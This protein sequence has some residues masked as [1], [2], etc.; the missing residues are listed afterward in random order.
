MPVPFPTA[1]PVPPVPVQVQV[2]VPLVPVLVTVPASILARGSRGEFG[3]IHR[4]TGDRDEGA[5]ARL[6]A[7]AAFLSTTQRVYGMRIG[8][9]EHVDWQQVG[10]LAANMACRMTADDPRDDETVGR[11]DNSSAEQYLFTDHETRT[12]ERLDP[13]ADAP[14]ETRDREESYHELHAYHRTPGSSPELTCPGRA[15]L[16]ADGRWTWKGLELDREANRVADEQLAMRRQAEGRDDEGGYGEGGITPAMRRIEAE[17][18]HG[19]L[20]PD[21]E[22]FALKSPDRFK[23]KLAKL[24]DRY[25]DE[26]ADKLASAIHDG[27]RF[28][29]VFP[30]EEYASGVADATERLTDAGYDLRL[31]KSSWDADDYRGVNSRWWDP[32]GKVLFEVQFHTPESWEA[33]QRTHDIYEKLCDT[34]ITPAE[35]K[36]LDEEQQRI[37]AAIPVPP[38]ADTITYYLKGQF[39]DR[40]RESYLLRC[41]LDGRRWG[42]PRW[43]GTSPLAGRGRH[44]GRNASP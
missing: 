3:G 44:P 6:V 29:L 2:L 30:A 4:A 1:I 14:A 33:K 9:T 7:S 25:P 20:I 42:R 11:P 37:V 8:N 36:Q 18:D 34:R 17:L 41:F 24:I 12:S 19:S 31:R 39:D 43:A 10:V 16:N 27:I 22:N 5:V 13:T 35:C 40:D 32:E 21:S 15:E 28:T 38:S 26:P 23:E